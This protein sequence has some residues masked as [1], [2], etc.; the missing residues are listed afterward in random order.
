MKEQVARKIFDRFFEKMDLDQIK[1]GGKRNAINEAIYQYEDWFDQ[2]KRSEDKIEYL[3][4]LPWIGPITKYHLA[5]NIG[6]DTVKPDRH[7]VRLAKRYGY[8]SPL[9]LCKEI[10]KTIPES[11]GVIDLILW[12]YC[13]LNTKDCICRAVRQCMAK[14]YNVTFSDRGI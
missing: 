13:N 6:I 1:H 8:N 3:D 10:Q 4:S 14:N 12:R 7:L 5:R 11:L 9:E 2:L